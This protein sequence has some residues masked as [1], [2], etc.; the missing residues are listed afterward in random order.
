LWSKGA[1]F[2]SE[3]DEKY[4]ASGNT[5]MREKYW[6][7]KTEKEHKVQEKYKTLYNTMNPNNQSYRIC[8]QWRNNI[9]CHAN[10]ADQKEMNCKKSW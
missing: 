7:R 10:N 5:I 8:R 9:R 3:K 1:I 2:I 4:Y 6:R